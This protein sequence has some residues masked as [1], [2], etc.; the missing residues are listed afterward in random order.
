M[1]EKLIYLLQEI[2]KLIQADFL[3]QER[4]KN[5]W[6]EF[7]FQVSEEKDNSENSP[8]EQSWLKNFFLILFSL[9]LSL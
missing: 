9:P 5:Y 4:I 8:E 1:K 7:Y 2:E 6:N 3:D